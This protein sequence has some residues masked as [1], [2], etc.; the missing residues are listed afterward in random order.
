MSAPVAVIVSA[1]DRASLVGELVDALR[2]QSYGD[3]EAVLVDNGSSDDTEAALRRAVGDDPRFRILRL[4]GNRGPG[5]AR[6]HGWRATDAPLVAFTDDDCAPEPGWLEA[7]VASAADADIVQGRTEHGRRVEG[8]VPNWF[9]RSQQIR[10]WS[11]RF[12]TCNLAIRREWLLRLDGFDERFHIAMG[13]DTDFGLRA[14]ALGARTAFA[15]EAVV[16]HHIWAGSFRLFVQQRRR[17]AEVVELFKVNPAARELLPGRFVLRGI[18]LVVLGLIP[19][20]AVGVAVGWWWAPSLVVPA[21]VARNVVATSH[22]PF[23]V[24]RR[25]GNSVLQFVGYAYETWCFVRAS[26]RYRTV[27]L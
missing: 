1:Y 5:R 7:L 10:S 19:A 2:A 20:T 21:W 14:V 9:D 13:E 4:E 26:V 23:S 3:F 15:D 11:R 17:Y 22:R 24:P 18:H 27:V 25:I 12:E 6:N 8:S 16:R